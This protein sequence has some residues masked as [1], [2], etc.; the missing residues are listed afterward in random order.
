MKKILFLFIGLVLCAFLNAQ[1]VLNDDVKARI[2]T[3]IKLNPD[4]FNVF[5]ASKE[6]KAVIDVISTSFE[7]YFIVPD[8]S[9]DKVTSSTDRGEI[10]S[11]K[12]RLE[13]LLINPPTWDL[14]IEYQNYIQNAPPTP[15]V[16]V[17]D[18]EAVKYYNSKYA[19]KSRHFSQS[20]DSPVHISNSISQDEKPALES[21]FE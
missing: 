6:G 13:D 2:G 12:A 14:I 15:P 10:I 4:I 3:Y 16:F 8:V 20:A 18:T 17:G 11:F 5:V 21:K 9:L 7:N 1:K 19:N